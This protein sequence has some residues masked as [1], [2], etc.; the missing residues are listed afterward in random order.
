MNCICVANN[1]IAVSR[2]SLI[3]FYIEEK[4]KVLKIQ[5]ATGADDD[6]CDMDF[7]N[8]QKYVAL[9]TSSKKLYTYK[10]PSLECV[11]SFLLP[12]SA[13]KVRFGAEK[14]NIFVADKTGDVLLYKIDNDEGGVKL[15]GHLSLL[16]NVLQSKD[17]NYLIT[18]DRDEKIRVSCYPHT[19]NI[20]T[21]CLGHKE[22]VNHLEFLPHN[23]KYL[24]SASGDGT[25]KCWDYAIGHNCCTI[26]TRTDVSDQSLQEDFKKMM[27]DDGIEVDGLPIVHFSTTKLNDTTSLIAVSLHSSHNV[28]IYTLETSDCKFKH[29]LLERVSLEGHP[30][31]LKLSETSLFVY[32][33]DTSKLTRF[34]FTNKNN[35][36]TLIKGH[37]INMFTEHNTDS[38]V[39]TD[40]EHIKV[41]FKRKFD[42]VQEYQERKRN[43]LVK[44]T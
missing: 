1:I 24:L 25:I 5:D 12:R 38:I 17:G 6:I 26:D 40:Y 11:K 44:A 15:L 10:F 2:G 4:H 39:K 9:L 7:S 36:T 43:R 34:N 20:Q 8:D 41:L 13:S 3:D 37:T 35:K 28:L 16:L 33:N 19:Y 22:F 30:G 21:Y 27:D 32:D 42:N 23:E 31:C 14:N 18:S 29:N